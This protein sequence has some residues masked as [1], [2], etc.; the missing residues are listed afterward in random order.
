M[1]RI[2]G[3]ATPDQRSLG[4]AQGYEKPTGASTPFFEIDLKDWSTLWQGPG[5]TNQVTAVG[6]EV[7]AIDCAAG[8]GRTA[9][10]VTYNMLLRQDA[11]TGAYYLEGDG[12]ARGYSVAL[13]LSGTKQIT[14]V[15]AVQS[16][17]TAADGV[18]MEFSYN[19]NLSA[20]SFYVFQQN[21][22]SFAC[23]SH[24]TSTINGY[25]GYNTE[26]THLN[27]DV[28]IA[29]QSDLTGTTRE[30][31]NIATRIDGRDERV[32]GG[33]TY[34]ANDITY[35]NNTMY[36]GGRGGNTY[37]AV[38]RIYGL[39]LYDHQTSYS[40]FLADQ[41]QYENLLR[42][43]LVP[44]TVPSGLA[45]TR[46]LPPT[47]S[48]DASAMS[49]YAKLTFDTCRLIEMGQTFNE[50]FVIYLQTGTVYMR[51]ANSSGTTTLTMATNSAYADGAELEICWSWDGVT[52]DGNIY[53]NGSNDRA[54]WVG[55][56]SGVVHTGDVDTFSIFRDVYNNN[57]PYTGA[58][59]RL[60]I[61]R[62]VTLDVTDAEVRR[63]MADH[64]QAH[65]LGETMIDLY[66]E[67]NVDRFEL[68][69][70]DHS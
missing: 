20:G 69:L 54:G 61:W 29:Y 30:T 8:T 28:V 49:G 53:V 11:T 45:L 36:I 3:A 48:A 1:S 42:P 38:G 47:N 52:P 14:A 51:G 26:T 2:I 44:V 25:S 46:K 16:N 7:E 37:N 43:A 17:E 4:A 63:K 24:S 18:V 65:H 31:T 70:G 21:T 50:R 9:T 34:T 67:T 56:G 60:C 66:A 27:D 10:K 58:F 64:T 15:L 22:G 59:T 39:K 68:G 33:G 32:S 40:D 19:Q 23:G 41:R 12:L 13:D 35:L 6:Q 5:R 62:D 57:G 55:P